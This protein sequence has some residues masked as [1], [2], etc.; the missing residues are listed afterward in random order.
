MFDIRRPD[1]IA[2][3]Q[4]RAI[5]LLHENFIRILVS[6]LSAYLRTYVSMS[7]ISVE[8]VSYR[9][10]LERMP[11]TGCLATLGLKPYEGNAIL[12]LDPPLIFPILEIL[13][14]GGGRLTT[15]IER[16]VTEI[17]RSLMDGL[18]RIISQDLREA[19]K[20]VAGIEFDVLSV[21][22]GA[23][24]VQAA[25]A[26]EA[27]LAVK[28]EVRLGEITGGMNI[29]MPSMV[30]HRL[31]QKFDYNRSAPRG[32]V[33]PDEQ[34]RILDLIQPSR[35][36]IDTRLQDQQ[37]RMGDLLNLRAGDVLTFD[38]PF[39]TPIDLVLNGQSEFKGSVVALERKRGFQLCA[40]SSL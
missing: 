28:F 19:W 20:S 17:E 32:E 24:L 37:I 21:G 35:V 3:S 40:A 26:I 25:T 33:S 10:F 6:N 27:V 36:E 18:F 4:L 7:L 15:A 11:E 5:Q 34:R 29:S 12:E 23:Q 9:G 22:T 31:R 8:Q 2:K 16:E 13:L 39:G 38:L 1:R 30:V 14:G